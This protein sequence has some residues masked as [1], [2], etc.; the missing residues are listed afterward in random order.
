[1]V[2][3]GYRALPTGLTACTKSAGRYDPPALVSTHIRREDHLEEEERRRRAGTERASGDRGDQVD[4][5]TKQV[6]SEVDE[7]AQGTCQG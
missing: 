7:R 6:L 1:M 3:A 2:T 4:R 5:D